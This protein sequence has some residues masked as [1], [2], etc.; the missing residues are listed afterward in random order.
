MD[1]LSIG[2]LLDPQTDPDAPLIALE[3]PSGLQCG[4]HDRT[5]QDA[6]VS[7]TAPFKD[8]LVADT[9]PCVHRACAYIKLANGVLNQSPPIVSPQGQIPRWALAL[10]AHN[11]TSL[12]ERLCEVISVTNRKL[13]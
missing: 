4:Y 7:C 11:C 5:D 1:Q 8:L 2:V 12:K 10:S 3:Q 13:I 6:F 9:F